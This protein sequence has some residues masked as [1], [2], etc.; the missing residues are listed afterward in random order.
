MPHKSNPRLLR[1]IVARPDL[2]ITDKQIDE[3]ILHFIQAFGSVVHVQ[4][5]DIAGHFDAEHP[6][7]TLAEYTELLREA[8]RLLHPRRVAYFA[9]SKDLF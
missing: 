9:G 2:T 8:E 6:Q 4:A 3:C 5:G 7:L 1:A